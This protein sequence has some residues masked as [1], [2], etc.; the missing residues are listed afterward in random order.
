MYR[1]DLDAIRDRGYSPDMYRMA[2]A[3]AHKQADVWDE[4]G[5]PDNATHER[6]LATRWLEI[7]E[8]LASGPVKETVSADKG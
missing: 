7:A 1:I 5:R 3:K 8:L 6:T 4:R 2:A